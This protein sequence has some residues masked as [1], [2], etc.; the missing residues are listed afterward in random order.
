MARY[1]APRLAGY[2]FRSLA[3]LFVFSVCAL[4]IWR[5]F[6][7]TRIPERIDTMIPNPALAEAYGEK[8][9]ELTL[10]YQDLATITRSTD[11]MGYFSVVECVFIPEARQIQLV[12]RY[13]NST[14][15]H[16]Q[17]DYKLAELPKKAD[18]L[19]DVTLVRTTDLTPS[20]RTDDLDGTT[21]SEERFF[22]SEQYRVREETALYTYY[23]YV[24]EDVTAED[25]TDGIYVDIYYTNDIT[26]TERSYGTLLIYA[27]DE[28]WI[29][30]EVT[31]ADWQA[32]RGE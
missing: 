11:R 2:V 23:R 17:A 6:F 9:E 16:L 31:K 5:V 19:F 24:F 13:N 3:A 1:R 10:Q 12:F 30:Y 14:I 26:Y 15:R 22:P 20:D 21:L 4:L 28:E 27:W 32:I 7:S 25:V 29:P 18:H 8:G